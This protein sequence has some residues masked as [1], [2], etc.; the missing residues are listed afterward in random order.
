M[1]TVPDGLAADSRARP[2]PLESVR[3]P[4]ARRG[5]ADGCGGHFRKT[6]HQ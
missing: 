5:Q 6:P 4:G 2:R 1:A 3:V